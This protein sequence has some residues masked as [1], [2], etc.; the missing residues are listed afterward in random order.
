MIWKNTSNISRQDANKSLI[1]LKD[2]LIFVKITLV[3]FANLH[4]Q[5]KNDPL[6]KC[7]FD[8]NTIRIYPKRH[9]NIQFIINN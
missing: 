8:Q 1:S 6:R 3:T 7:Q 5:A 2:N 4:L 9:Q